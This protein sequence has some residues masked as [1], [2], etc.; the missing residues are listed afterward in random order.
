LIFRSHIHA[1]RSRWE[2]DKELSFQ[3]CFFLVII[4]GIW[5][6]AGWNC[7]I[8]Q[9]LTRLDRPCCFDQFVSKVVNISRVLVACSV[10]LTAVNICEFDVKFY[11]VLSCYIRNFF[12]VEWYDAKTPSSQLKRVNRVLLIGFETFPFTL[13]FRFRSLLFRELNSSLFVQGI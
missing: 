4:L 3:L 8:C 9:I 13:F 1:I 6:L 2:W 12:N 7:T 10:P 5:I 11:I